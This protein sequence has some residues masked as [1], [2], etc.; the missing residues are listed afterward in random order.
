MCGVQ[1]ARADDDDDEEAE[2]TIMGD[3]VLAGEIVEQVR[4]D[5]RRGGTLLH[6]LIVCR[7]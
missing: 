1:K 7:T 4:N 2:E 6:D 5:S 3:M